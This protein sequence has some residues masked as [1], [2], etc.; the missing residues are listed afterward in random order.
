MSNLDFS[1]RAV[2]ITG[3]APGGIGAATARAFAAGGARVTVADIDER[4]AEVAKEVRGTF[5]RVDIADEAQ[6]ARLVGEFESLDVLVNNAAV[7]RPE[8]PIQD[9]T[10]DEFDLLMQ[11]NVRGTFLLCR[12]AYPLLKLSRGCIV[13]VSSMTGVHGARDHAA[14]SVTKGAVNAL[15][16]SLAADWGRDGIRVN[17]VCPSTVETENVDKIIDS[18]ENPAAIREARRGV[19]SL[20]AVASAGMIAEAILFL[21]SP[22]AAFIHGALVPVSGGS[23]CGYGQKC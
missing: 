11:V 19:T 14:Y 12:A 20:G 18:K 3:A 5:R 13:N 23:E 1:G 21:A 2:L 6:V 16:Q 8:K 4:A 7:L 15:T 10:T 9:T 22:G 17:A